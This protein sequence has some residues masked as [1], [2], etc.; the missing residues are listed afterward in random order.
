MEK[1]VNELIKFEHT[2]IYNFM[3]A[4][5]N[6]RNSHE[7][8]DKLDSVEYAYLDAIEN[9][10]VSHIANVEF[11]LL[12]AADGTLARNLVKAGPDHAK[13]MRQILVS[14]DIS[15]G[16]EWWKEADTYKV[17]TVANSTSLMHRLGKRLLIVDDFSFDKP[18][19]VVAEKQVQVANEAIQAWIDSGKKQGTPE[20]RDMQKA[21]PMSFV[22]KRGFT[23][24]YQV[25]QNMYFARKNHR[26]NEW[27]EFADWVESLPYSELITGSSRQNADIIR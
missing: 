15:A 19:S 24:N 21:I 27:H 13:F 6:M 2:K 14:V 12:G 18:A 23:C 1:A 5:R 10:N 11:F 8:W 17:G 7:S 26:L 3:G 16:N 9:E 20:W 22:Y 4:I 25:L